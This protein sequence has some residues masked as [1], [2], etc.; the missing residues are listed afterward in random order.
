VKRWIFPITMQLV[1]LVAFV[2]SLAGCGGGGSSTTPS[3][4]KTP[5][6][7]GA[8]NI[9]L[10]ENQAE[11]IIQTLNYPAPAPVST[12]QTEID[13]N[14]VQ[15]GGVLSAQSNIPAMNIGC[16]QGGASEWQSG[17]WLFQNF[18][19]STG[20][21]VNEALNISLAENVN[22]IDGT[23]VFTGTIQPDG[24]LAG[25]VADSC[26]GNQA[27]WAATRILALPTQ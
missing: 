22:K 17:G 2:L 11:I 16:R 5:N 19:F 27:T 21:L 14:L 1:F 23:L 15:S 18:T 6:L 7:N 26:T 10:S 20:T 8:W 12:G 24:S 13:I 9:Q 4:P 3:T 25:T